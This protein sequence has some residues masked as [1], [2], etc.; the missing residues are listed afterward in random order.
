M[1]RIAVTGASG[2][3]GS[4][5]V[6]RLI[7]DGHAV[8]ALLRPDSRSPVVED[9]RVRVIR[10]DVTDPAAVERTVAGCDVVV[11]LARAKAH[12][13]LPIHV[14]ESVNVGGAGTVAAVASR[15]G[16]ARLV[17]GSSTAV[18]GA[19][20]R[21]QPVTESAPVRPDSAYARSKIRA[22]Q[23][24][25]SRAGSTLTVAIARITTVV[26]P[27]CTSWLPLIRSIRNRQLRLVGRGDNWHHP[28][29]VADIV[30]GLVRCAI[31][32][33]LAHSVYNLAGPEPVR[34]IELVRII[35]GELGVR[36]SQPRPAP[37]LPVRLY[38]RLNA[39]TDATWGLALPRAAS[40]MFLGSDR[41]LDMSRAR[42]DLSYAPEV[43]VR[44]GIRRMIA[45]HREHGLI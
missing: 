37:A 21:M 42:E 20:P 1:T 17:L 40:A 27:R 22:E 19:R 14:V 9:A 15:A 36:G 11:H 25:L 26:G 12:S 39:F 31:A 32:P 16:V 4:H 43:G 28:A 34:A 41:V 38:V 7:A 3:I 30:D 44:D 45:W 24:T 2:F 8:V 29:D 13:G 33:R 6:E 23:E 35:A 10:G 5:L 18:Y